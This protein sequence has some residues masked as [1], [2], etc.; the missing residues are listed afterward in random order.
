M[1]QQTNIVQYV[2]QTLKVTSC[3]KTVWLIYDVLKTVVVICLY[4]DHTTGKVVE[5]PTSTFGGP[6]VGGKQ[7][8]GSSGL[9][10]RV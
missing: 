2:S 6:L 3:S 9:V 4:P 8:S 10:L 7:A 1:S 5:N